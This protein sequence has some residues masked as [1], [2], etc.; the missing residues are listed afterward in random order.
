MDSTLQSTLF[1]TFSTVAQTL[2][3]A[4]G[5]LAAIVLFALQSTTKSIERAAKQ[6]IR[7]PHGPAN[8]ALHR[9]LFTRKSYHELARTFGQHFEGGTKPEI[10]LHLMEQYSTLTWFLDHDRLLRRS[11]MRALIS[12][13]V[14]TSAALAAIGFVPELMDRPRIAETL[15]WVIILGAVGCLLLYGILMRVMLAT[16]P[17]E[18]SQR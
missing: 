14:V 4:M 15:L 3:G 8:T 10:N 5:L 16:A 18:E 12:S 7:S 1:Y 2:A 6:L 11:F 9:H 17:D 13:G